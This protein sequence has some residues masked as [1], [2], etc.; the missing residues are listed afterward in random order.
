MVKTH[1]FPVKIFPTKP[2]HWM[3]T[4][5]YIQTIIPLSTTIHP[6]SATI[7]METTIGSC[8]ISMVW[9]LLPAFFGGGTVG[10]KRGTFG[11]TWEMDPWWK[12]R[13]FTG[14]GPWVDVPKSHWKTIGK[15]ENHRKTIGKWWLPSGKH[16]KS[17][18]EN[19]HAIHGKTHYFDWVIFNSYVSHY[20]RV[21]V[22]KSH[23]LVDE[24]MGLWDNFGVWMKKYDEKQGV[25][26]T[27]LKNK[28]FLWW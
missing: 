16:R 19:H 2:I 13:G 3:F 6:W 1:G 26:R 24:T 17:W 12:P 27:P 15:W 9:W 8:G 18:W 4:R 25:W 21:D 5:G 10:S 22:P 28:R 20:Q 7:F 23:W 11:A 14:V